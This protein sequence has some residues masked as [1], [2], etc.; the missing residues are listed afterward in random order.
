MNKD[1]KMIEYFVIKKSSGEYPD[2]FILFKIGQNLLEDLL[3]SKLGR[4]TA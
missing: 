4:V 3:H 2:D 1:K